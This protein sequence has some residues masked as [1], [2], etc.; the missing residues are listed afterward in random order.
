MSKIC[1]Y[2]IVGAG[3]TGLCCAW[4]LT[5]KGYSCVVLEKTNS[6]GGCHRA[7]RANSYYAM[8][9][10]RIYCD[11]YKHMNILHDSINNY[12]AQRGDTTY[13]LEFDKL[14]APFNL[15]KFNY[16]AFT[17]IQSV[18]NSM[19][20]FDMGKIAQMFVRPG[21][22]DDQSVSDY[23]QEHSFTMSAQQFIDRLCRL[24]D[25]TDSTRTPVRK[26]A[27]LPM[28]GNIYQLKHATDKYLF[29][30]YAK[31]FGLAGI[32]IHLNTIA[33]LNDV[34]TTCC[35]TTRCG[36]KIHEVISQ[37]GT[38]WY[39]K[40]IICAVPPQSLHTVLP[41]I[42]M[43]QQWLK[44][45][46]Y[47]SYFSLM[48]HWRTKLSIAE[49]IGTTMT[50]WD[51]A[52]MVVSNYI[53]DESPTMLCVLVSNA[54]AKSAWSRK[55]ALE[56]STTEVIEETFRQLRLLLD[57]PKYD[58]AILANSPNDYPAFAESSN[59]RTF[60]GPTI[61][62]MNNIYSVGSHNGTTYRFT[63]M[64]SA[65]ESAYQFVNDYC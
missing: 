29:A 5:I 60:Y 63:T 56:C 15:L 24:T 43:S 50:D 28:K 34:R 12:L 58:V 36:T 33:Q 23:I 19:S 7:M 48:F 45:H 6:I 20:L 55:S 26:F 59:D 53:K 41:N 52:Y 51:L 40:N 25:G 14:F 30:H 64:E 65:I 8:H 35:G 37:N 16:D 57:V 18:S 27:S 9:G 39:G 11:T 3:P 17:T 42:Q 10:P 4:L 22:R 2:I 49:G 46:S 54:H 62:S 31:A 44:E 1:D 21:T 61:Q 47:I 32:K 38:T 13:P